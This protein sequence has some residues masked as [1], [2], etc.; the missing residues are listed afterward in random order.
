MTDFVS[1]I[2]RISHEKFEKYERVAKGREQ[3]PVHQ[4]PN[5]FP[6][7]AEYTTFVLL[8]LLRLDDAL[9]GINL[10]LTIL[11]FY[12]ANISSLIFDIFH[13]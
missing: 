5:L 4:P 10:D 9:C 3:A 2:R 11:I 1:T 12:N 13:C 7:P 8:L 6:V